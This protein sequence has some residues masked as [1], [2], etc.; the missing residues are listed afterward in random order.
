MN[1]G[2]VYALIMV[3]RNRIVFKEVDVG[4]MLFCI[5]PYRKV[6]STSQYQTLFSTPIEELTFGHYV[7]MKALCICYISKNKVL[8]VWTLFPLSVFLRRDSYSSAVS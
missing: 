3:S 7:D 8:L 5:F 2:C 4:T 1:S 6:L